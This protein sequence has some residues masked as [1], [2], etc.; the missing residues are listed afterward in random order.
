MTLRTSLARYVRGLLSEEPSTPNASSPP[1]Q[2]PLSTPPTTTPS[3]PVTSPAIS[4]AG[5]LQ[6]VLET[7]E[8]MNRENLREMRELTISILQ[9]R[10]SDQ[11][12]TSDSTVPQNLREPYDPPDYD[13]PG[14]ED[15]PGGIQSIFE[16]ERQE[17]NDFRHLRTER[18][19]LA[20]QLEE[21]RAMIS[22]PQGPDF[23]PSSLTD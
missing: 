9:G 15:L 23:M 12:P 7:M 2:S 14:T 20:A 21:S 13:D 22:D 4:E 5:L 16:R 18:E 10:D 11:P 17:Q 19:V 3:T 6:V 8:R 1:T